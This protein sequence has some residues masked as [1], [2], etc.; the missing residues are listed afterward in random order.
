[1]RLPVSPILADSPVAGASKR[2]APEAQA[3]P[4]RTWNCQ[5]GPLRAR[6]VQAR[7]VQARGVQGTGDP[8]QLYGAS[9]RPIPPMTP[10]RCARCLLQQ[11]R[12]DFEDAGHS[13]RTFGRA[14]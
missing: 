10:V 2:R 6:G 3:E 5:P 9:P 14:A 13:I 1:M 4:T 11:P 12:S 7:G 8:R